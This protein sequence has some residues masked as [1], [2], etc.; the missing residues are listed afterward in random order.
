[1]FEK[2]YANLSCKQVT[3][4]L[5]CQW[6]LCLGDG[7]VTATDCHRWSAVMLE[8][9]ACE[10]G[11]EGCPQGGRDDPDLTIFTFKLLFLTSGWSA[12]YIS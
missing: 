4:A 12:I 7:D 9:R 10:P 3:C 11:L 6:C 5:A 2:Y 8:H 1:M